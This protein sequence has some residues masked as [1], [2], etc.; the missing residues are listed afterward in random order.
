MERIRILIVDDHELIRRGLGEAFEDEQDIEVIGQAANAV[1]T[2]SLL[3]KVLPDVAL[4]DLQLPDVDGVELCR[5]ILSRDARIRCLI[6]TSFGDEESVYRAVLA[7]ASG[8]LLKGMPVA[9]VVD[10]V[11]RT[12]AGQSLLD[13]VVTG[14]LLE[15]LRSPSDSETTPLTPQEARV[16]DLVAEGLTNTDI[17]QRLYLAEQTVKNYVS[18]ILSKLGMSTRTQA[19]VYGADLKRRR[20]PVTKEKRPGETR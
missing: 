18:N 1:E 9:D 15:R 11:R 13:P 17:A 2:L 12:A 10:A 14:R 4:L 20:G 19:A 3:D 16:L 6:L 7:G 8:Y 5:E